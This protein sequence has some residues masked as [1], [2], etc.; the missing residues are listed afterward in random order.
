MYDG[1]C[2]HALFAHKLT[3]KERDTETNLDNFGARY[4]SSSFG[5][6]MSP[7]DP[8]A[9]QDPHNPQS[10]NLYTYARNNP[11]RFTDARVAHL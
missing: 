10:W 11:V 1:S 2:Q 7:D 5:R 9:D 4:N 3:G 8:N 6:F